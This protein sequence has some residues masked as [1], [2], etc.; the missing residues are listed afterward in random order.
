[1]EMIASANST[2]NRVSV[3]N[4]PLSFAVSKDVNVVDNPKSS[5]HTEKLSK[6]Q[7]T[8]VVSSDNSGNESFLNA[9]KK[10]IRLS[11]TSGHHRTPIVVAEQADL[12]SEYFKVAAHLNSDGRNLYV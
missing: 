3:T 6:H 11:K 4:D 12:K 7:F 9:G 2:F 8:T 1:M 5:N 10:T